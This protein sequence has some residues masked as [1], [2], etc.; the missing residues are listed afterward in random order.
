MEEQ[1]GQDESPEGHERISYDRESTGA[2]RGCSVI[3][4][5]GARFSVAPG[6]TVMVKADPG[7]HPYV[8][9]VRKVSAA[10]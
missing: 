6:D 1:F 5:D 10:P 2:I 3:N 7:K 8:A 9:F 4:C